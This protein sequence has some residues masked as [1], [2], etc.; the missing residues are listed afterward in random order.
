VTQEELE[1]SFSFAEQG[2]KPQKG[3][4]ASDTDGGPWRQPHLSK[5]AGPL[6][7]MS[8]QEAVPISAVGKAGA[9]PQQ[10]SFQ[11]FFCWTVSREGAREE[12]S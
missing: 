3:S 8:S 10:T 9:L 4:M 12:L 7:E 1:H 6:P 2:S 5:D 11:K